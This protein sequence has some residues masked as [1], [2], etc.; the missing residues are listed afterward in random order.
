MSASRSHGAASASER[1]SCPP[2]SSRRGGLRRR[3]RAR[4]P[5]LRERQLHANCK[6]DL[7]CEQLARGLR[8]EPER[9]SLLDRLF[10]HLLLACSIDDRLAMQVLPRCDVTH[11]LQTLADQAEHLAD[12]NI[13]IGKRRL[14][15]S[16]RCQKEQEEDRER[17]E[18]GS[19]AYTLSAAASPGRATG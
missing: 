12:V 13:R 10:E 6:P 8:L 14:C 19:A 17:A 3:R 2:I 1:R 5:A 18:H 16:G 4:L 9:R 11:Q 15:A 7:E